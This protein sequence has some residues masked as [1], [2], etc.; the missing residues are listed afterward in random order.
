M[1]AAVDDGRFF[2]LMEYVSVP[3][4]CN[5]SRVEWL[6]YGCNASHRHVL[7]WLPVPCR[8]STYHLSEKLWW[9]DYNTDKRTTTNEKNMCVV[10]STDLFSGP[11]RVVGPMCVSVCPDNNL[12]RGRIVVLSPLAAT[13]GFVRSWP[14]ITHDSLDSRESAPKRHLDRFSLFVLLTCVPNTR[15]CTQTYRPRYIRH[16]CM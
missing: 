12:A 13:N 2:C 3:T 1:A 5:V 9:T 4:T 8:V 14:N 15:A 11:G 6:R 16:T 7:Q 10:S